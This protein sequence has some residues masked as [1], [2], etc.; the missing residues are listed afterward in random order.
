VDRQ[1]REAAGG[2]GVH[3]IHAFGHSH[4]PKDFELN[5]VRYYH[6]PVGKKKE[7]EY[8]MLC[9]VPKPELLFSSTGPAPPPEKEVIRYWEL[10]GVKPPPTKKKDYTKPGAS[11]KTFF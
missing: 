1:M 4:R 9:E 6:N 3:H 5:G 10:M 11:S 2:T 8:K 7:R